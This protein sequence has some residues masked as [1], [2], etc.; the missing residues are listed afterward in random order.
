MGESN[1]QILEEI[2]SEREALEK[3]QTAL[4]HPR[5]EGA[6]CGAKTSSGTPC[7][8]API[9]GGNRC[10]LHGGGSPLARAAAERRLLLGADLAID[11]LLD[12][13]VEH[14][15]PP[16]ELCGCAPGRADPNTL[17]AAIAVLDRTGFSPGVRLLHSTDDEESIS[18][19]RI[20]IVDV[21]PEQRAQNEDSDREVEAMR[22]AERNESFNQEIDTSEPEPDRHTVSFDLGTDLETDR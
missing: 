14:D 12:S 15:H 17:R 6:L 16:C 1:Q 3:V 20:N 5:R 4:E 13:L 18:E 2:R 10:C 19:I 7:K 8:R 9:P 21:S 22:R 11:R